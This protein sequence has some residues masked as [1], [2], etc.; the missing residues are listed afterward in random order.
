MP[1]TLTDVEIWDKLSSCLKACIQGCDN[2]AKLPAMGPTY[3]K[4]IVDLEELEGA[5]RQFGTARE[6][7]RWNHFGWEMA[8]FRQRIGDAIRAHEP[9]M[10]FLS[11]KAMIEVYQGTALAMKDAKTGKRGPI[12]PI[13]RPGPHRETRPVYVK[14]QGGVLL[15]G[16][17]A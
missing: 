7:A 14:S 13:Q 10:V 2:L 15:P 9:R 6:D 4:M 11:M 3:R 12:L 8:R 1:T 16:G 5:A 17:V